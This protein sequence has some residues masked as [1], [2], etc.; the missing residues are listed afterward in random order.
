MSMLSILIV[1]FLSSRVVI[2]LIYPNQKPLGLV[3]AYTFYA[4][5]LSMLILTR[6]ESAYGRKIISTIIFTV[7]AFFIST[8]Y[9]DIP[10]NEHANYLI[11]ILTPAIFLLSCTAS[12][13]D[14]KRASQSFKK[15]A[16]IPALI[17]ACGASIYSFTQNNTYNLSIFDYFTNSPNHVAAQ[18]IVKISFVF[19]NN[20]LISL[21]AF[22]LLFLLNVRSAIISFIIALTIHHKKSLLARK[23][24][25]KSLPLI[26]FA[27]IALVLLL[28]LNEIINR[29]V[30]RGR[31]EGFSNDLSNISSGR[32]EIFTY[33]INHIISNFS[34]VDWLFGRGPI[35]LNS[36]EQ[37]LSAHNDILNLITSIGLVGLLLIATSYYLF[38][39][40]IPAKIRA[41]AIAVFITLFLTN[42]IAF[43]QS[44]ILFAL[45]YL[46]HENSILRPQKNH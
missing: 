22:G 35:W 21:L 20:T 46:Y 13:A 37:N 5:T 18:T 16:A 34:A 4:I 45:L 19:I 39:S 26:A 23:N 44:N 43:H 10:F 6:S 15:I 28:D 9:S 40:S 27:S 31:I 1:V 7:A 38:F 30:F 33:Y 17:L 32:T 2:D 11:Q 12:P 3:F 29:L 41:P 42:G 25:Y 8:L 24:I 14:I 36:H